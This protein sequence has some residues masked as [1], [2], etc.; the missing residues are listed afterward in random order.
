[1]MITKTAAKM[2]TDAALPMVAGG[3]GLPTGL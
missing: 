3:Y 1:M 2:E